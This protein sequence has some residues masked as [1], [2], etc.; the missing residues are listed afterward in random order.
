MVNLRAS[1]RNTIRAYDVLN[2]QR[3]PARGSYFIID[4]QGMIR[5]KK[6]PGNGEGLGPNELLIEEVQKINRG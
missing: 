2:S 6:I 3:A 4:K 5:Y 1:N